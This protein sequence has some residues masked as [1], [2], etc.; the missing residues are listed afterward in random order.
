MLNDE[1]VLPSAPT[2]STLA[3]NAGGPSRSGAAV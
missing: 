2:I 3:R 1:V